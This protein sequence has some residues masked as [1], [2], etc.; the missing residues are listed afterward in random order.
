MTAFWDL[1]DPHWFVS[2]VNW[3]QSLYYHQQTLKIEFRYKA[4]WSIN[5]SVSWHCLVSCLGCSKWL[6][7]K[8]EALWRTPEDAIKRQIWQVLSEKEN[9]YINIT[10]NSE[11]F[12]HCLHMK[13]YFFLNVPFNLEQHQSNGSMYHFHIDLT[14]FPGSEYLVYMSAFCVCLSVRPPPFLLKIERQT[15]LDNSKLGWKRLD[16][17]WIPWNSLEYPGLCWIR[18]E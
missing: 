16:Y 7:P 8:R 15:W 4:P 5:W 13:K 6:F 17:F 9:I 1:S 18:L 2:Y 3:M 10:R 14:K 11:H 12:S